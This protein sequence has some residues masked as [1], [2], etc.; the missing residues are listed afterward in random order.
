M[1]SEGNTS[2]VHE[3]NVMSLY[4]N[5][6]VSSEKSD[7]LEQQQH[8]VEVTVTNQLREDSPTV[9]VKKMVSLRMQSTIVN[10]VP[11]KSTES[12]EE[13]V[14]AEMEKFPILLPMKG[15]ENTA[16]ALDDERL[17]Q[18]SELIAVEKTPV[19]LQ[20]EP[21][22]D[23]GV[24]EFNDGEETVGEIS[25]SE[26][27]A[28]DVLDSH[29]GKQVLNSNGVVNHKEDEKALDRRDPIEEPSPV[30]IE[31][32]PASL[33]VEQV[34]HEGNFQVQETIDEASAV[35]VKSEPRVCDYHPM[36]E[37]AV[38]D[39]NVDGT[40]IEVEYEPATTTYESE[41]K[42]VSETREMTAEESPV[43][44]EKRPVSLHME[45]TFDHKKDEEIRTPIEE[46]PLEI[47]NNRPVSLHMDQVFNEEGGV[48]VQEP[49]E[50]ASTVSVESEPQVCDYHPML[51]EAEEKENDD[52]NSVEVEYEPVAMTSGNKNEMGTE[53]KET[54]TEE[55]PFVVEKRPVSLQIE[56][57][58]DHK[59]DE[60]VRKPLEEAP[61]EIIE[62][63]PVSLHVDQI[64][65]E[66]ENKEL[67]ELI[68]EASA[69]SVESEPRVCD[70]HPMLE[71]N[72]ENENENDDSNSVEVDYEPVAMTSGNKDE[73]GT[74]TK[75]T[76]TEES[77]FVEEKR[78]VSLHMQAAFDQKEDEEV[79]EPIEEIPHEIIE[80]RPVFLN[81]DQ[82]FNEEG[83][84]ELQEPIE[85]ASAVAVK[86]ELRVCDYHPM[87]EETV[88]D[89]NS[90]GN[91]VEVEYEPAAMTLG[92]KDEMGTETK[93]TVTEESPLVVE[94][95]PVVLHMETGVDHKEDEEVRKP[96]EEVPHEISVK[97]PLSLHVDQIFIEE[98]NSEV[99]KPIEEASAVAVETDPRLLDYHPMLEERAED[100]NVLGNSV[101]VEYEPVASKAD[102]KEETKTETGPRE[103][104]AEES[105]LVVEKRPVSPHIEA[106]FDQKEDVK[107]PIEEDPPQ[108]IEKRPVSL[109]MENILDENVS[110]KVQEPIEEASAV[111]VESE[112]RVCDYH[113][114][115]EETVEDKNVDG[116][117]VEVEYEP[118]ATTHENEEETVSET[119]KMIAEE[120]PFVVE[121]RRAS[122]HLEAVFEHKE[123]GQVKEPIEEVPLEIIEK[124]PVSLHMEQMFNQEESAEAQE[125][126]QEASAVAVES[127]PRV[128]DYHPMLEDTLED[129]NV[130]E[131]SVEVDYE[132]AATTQKNEKL[133]E[134]EAKEAIAEESPFVVENR[135]ASL[136]L[137]AV[138]EQK[139][140]GEVKNLIEEAPLEVIDKRPVSLHMEQMF[141]EEGSVEVREPLEEASAV[142][143]E[144]EPKVYD[145]HPMLEETEEDENVGGNSV[146]V[147]YEPAAVKL[148]FQGETETEAKDA[149][150][151]ESPLVVEKRPASLHV[152]AVFKPKEEVNEPVEEA[153]HAIIEKRPV[154]LH[155][156]QVFNEDGSTEVQEPTEESSAVAV[157]TEPRLFHYHPML[158]EKAEDNNVDTKSVEVEYEPAATK[159]EREEET[160]TGTRETIA[161]E[162]PLVVEKR[163]ASPHLEVV[164]DHDK[165]PEVGKPIEETPPIVVEKTPIDNSQENESVAA[166][167]PSSVH[168]L[169]I[170]EVEKVKE[171][172]DSVQDAVASAVERKAPEFHHE[173]LQTVETEEEKPED[174]TLEVKVEENQVRETEIL[175]DEGQVPELK[176]NELKESKRSEVITKTD[177]I[178]TVTI[179][180]RAGDETTQEMETNVVQ[181]TYEKK[182]MEYS[183]TSATEE[184]FGS[185][186]FTKLYQHGRD[187]D[188]GDEEELLRHVLR[189]RLSAP[190]V[191]PEKEN[192][193]SAP[194]AASE[195]RGILESQEQFAFVDNSR[196]KDWT[197]INKPQVSGA[198]PSETEPY[199]DVADERKL[200]A[201]APGDA[202]VAVDDAVENE[203]RA[204]KSLPVL[205]LL[206]PEKEKGDHENE[207]EKGKASR[208]S[209]PQCKCCSLM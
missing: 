176:G 162:S 27:G 117:C 152:E 194:L 161:D 20:M 69:V 178:S 94:K 155:M 120:S 56:A 33:H 70:Y 141:N 41:E 84:K 77:P 197:P 167:Q 75:E 154:L 7:T 13:T 79:R 101:E 145:Y 179:N 9:V 58:F 54:I 78:P 186:S 31:K 2:L 168:V 187:D 181:T 6:Q 83:N 207:R 81:V 106:A 23:S 30:L 122:L 92:N 156:E 53:T 68:D 26:Q 196:K 184:T 165:G 87:L 21:T 205:L 39:E 182:T 24:T 173:L 169:D 49:I 112:P 34:L 10:G 180:Q 102:T 50:E 74:E 208:P 146:E 96:I 42:T 126:I 151:E 158:E 85:E 107:A 135:P 114:M 93:E 98:G 199:E 57:A 86:S 172:E 89:E 132:P 95:K 99:Q 177:V 175:D 90:D 209:S 28:E 67:Q 157:E 201:D 4:T 113:P 142:A 103:T 82:I 65:I 193:G 32:R 40:C 76:I 163:P 204:G 159:R 11:V 97:R 202:E 72:E 191:L 149:I 47:I 18:E 200:I 80:K 110:D 153:P 127:E 125:P 73:M 35:A 138:F 71:E 29:E 3:E 88:A 190:E 123:E 119:K 195:D 203:E 91:F 188:D 144:S 140:E 136:H 25:V 15:P 17:I 147:E 105:P 189:K 164:V 133:T 44:V 131:N 8:I 19:F 22:F 198:T 137:E 116:N 1:A 109:H 36:L 12:V 66:E 59:E 192:D 129:E 148:D 108:I 185:T 128:C 150:T 38:E 166:E 62:K 121:K 124:R 14:A 5:G 37:R 46:A 60:E 111:V 174:T 63:R 43:V 48:G 170:P 45:V 104:V 183:N 55:S 61:H 51:E 118:A 64:F 139:E 206:T 160:K 143:V 130:D 52:S 16:V 115:L 134:T 100:E 171:V